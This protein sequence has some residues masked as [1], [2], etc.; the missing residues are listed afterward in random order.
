MS[1]QANPSE[2]V[3]GRIEIQQYKADSSLIWVE[4]SMRMYLNGDAELEVIGV[5]RDIA[6]RKEIEALQLQKATAL[7]DSEQRFRALFSNN[8]SPMYLFD[9]KTGQLVD[10]NPA[11]ESFYGWTREQFLLR[12]VR[13]QYANPEEVEDRLSRLA[14]DKRFRFE[15]KHTKSDGTR[16]D[17]EIFSSL[18]Q[19]GGQTLVHSI[20]HDISKRNEYFDAL[21]AQN[22]ILK[23]I[24]RV[25]SHEVRAPLARLMALIMLIEDESFTFDPN[26]HGLQ[27][28]KEV[29]QEILKSA[30]ELDGIIRSISEKTMSVHH[31]AIRI[32]Q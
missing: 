20:V 32:V 2:P 3:T 26:A 5:T 28:D 1:F 14:V 30:Y 4:L 12:N 6:Q 31:E 11:A 9:F 25:Q 29:L 22:K 16:C 8:A 24:A 10:V 23:E 17:V 27:S 7:H 13:D 18:I 15:T 19:L 21:I